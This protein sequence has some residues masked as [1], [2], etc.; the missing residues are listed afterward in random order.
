MC[1]KKLEEVCNFLKGQCHNICKFPFYMYDENRGGRET[2][3][4]PRSIL[5]PRRSM[6]I[7]LLNMLLLKRISVSAQCKN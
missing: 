1:C 6:F 7:C 2:L 5:G 4:P 3:Y